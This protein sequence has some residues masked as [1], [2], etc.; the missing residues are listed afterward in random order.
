M[1]MKLHIAPPS[2]RAIKVVALK[3][4]LGLDCEIRVLNFSTGDHTTPEFA[5]LNPNK[6]MPVLEDDGFVLWESNAILQYLAAKKPERGLW[7][8]DPKRQ[9][10]VLRWMS[11]ESAHWAPNGCSILIRENLLKRIFGGGDPDPA[12]IARGE[13]E[14]H[15]F[16]GVLDGS[17]KGRKWL[18]G[19]DLTIADYSVGAWMAVAQL[20]QYPLASYTEINRWYTALSSQPGWKEAIV[21]PPL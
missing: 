8:S 10:D 11:W 18:T 5:V 19:N 14:F 1:N 13:S 20:A 7:P 4:N 15:R 17:L 6:L 21:P 3:N 9:S 2:P 16:A 12:E